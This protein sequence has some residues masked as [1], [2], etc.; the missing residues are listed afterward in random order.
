MTNPKE[1]AGVAGTPTPV[2]QPENQDKDFSAQT[3]SFAIVDASVLQDVDNPLAKQA[4]IVPTK[5]DKA[6][7]TV[8]TEYD[9]TILRSLTITPKQSETEPEKVEEPGHE[10]HTEKGTP[11]EVVPPEVAKDQGVPVPSEGNAAPLSHDDTVQRA[12]RKHQTPRSRQ[13]M[14]G[15]D[16]YRRGSPVKKVLA[17]VK[18]DSRHQPKPEVEDAFQFILKNSGKSLTEEQLKAVK[19]PALLVEV[20][21]FMLAMMFNNWNVVEEGTTNGD[22]LIED[23]RFSAD[24]GGVL[25]YNSKKFNL[26]FDWIYETRYKLK[27]VIPTQTWDLSKLVK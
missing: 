27:R 9:D 11:A 14:K 18:R 26:A 10:D 23:E 2:G 17:R 4:I 6:V 22:Y 1:P 13:H 12:L 20:M 15:S 5:F 19:D 3:G 7:F 25:L 24:D 21:D 16:L 8:K